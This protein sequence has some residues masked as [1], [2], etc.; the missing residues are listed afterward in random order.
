M[1]NIVE[2]SQNSG[3]SKKSELKLTGVARGSLEELAEDYRYFLDH[4]GLAKWERDDPQRQ[5]LIDSRPASLDDFVQWVENTHAAQHSSTSTE[6]TSSTRSTYAEIAANG[7]IA[8][9]T[10]ACFLLDRQ[11]DSQGKSFEQDGGF[12]ERLYA[13][14]IEHRNDVKLSEEPF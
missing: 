10:V 12:T 6:S 5:A 9:V 3:T 4:R 11:L 13:R 7:A 2:G 14:R 1:Q 8:L